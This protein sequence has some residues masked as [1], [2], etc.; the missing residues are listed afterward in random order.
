VRVATPVELSLAATLV[1][2]A[3]REVPAVVAAATAAIADPASGLFSPARMGIGQRLYRSAIDAALMVPGVVAVHQLAVGPVRLI[4]LDESCR[5]A[6]RRGRPI[7]FGGG[8]RSLTGDVL[9][10]GLYSFFSLAPDLVSIL[11]V[12]AGD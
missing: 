7:G 6:F 10:P 8:S 5:L 9:D 4:P 11:G 3:D 12:S 2:A 1:V